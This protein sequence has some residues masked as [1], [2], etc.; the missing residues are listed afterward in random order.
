[1]TVALSLSVYNFHTQK[2]VLYLFVWPRTK[3]RG[4]EG[5]W[6]NVHFAGNHHGNQQIVTIKLTKNWGKTTWENEC[7]NDSLHHS[8]NQTINQSVSRHSISLSVAI[9][10]ITKCL[11][12]LPHTTETRDRVQLGGCWRRRNWWINLENRIISIC[13][14][15]ES[16]QI[17][18]C[19]DASLM[20]G[21]MDVASVVHFC[22][23]PA[24]ETNLWN[25]IF[26][27]NR[28]E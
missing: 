25:W 2:F 27:A 5:N 18:S 17:S 20:A 26:F 15:I 22:V 3:D 16:N 10:S 21:A 28:E 12:I 11:S 13:H 6:I 9:K 24:K 8:L 1:M 14:G 23:F 4:I 19:S 7:L